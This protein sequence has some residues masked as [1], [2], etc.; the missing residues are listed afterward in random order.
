[1]L[2][3]LP[4]N[5]AGLRVGSGEQ[6]EGCASPRHGGTSTVGE[7]IQPKTLPRCAAS[8]VLMIPTATERRCQNDSR[9]RP[10][11]P[12]AAIPRL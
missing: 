5:L 10:G 6:N 8:Y 7:Y 4:E 12:K 11:L 1:M 2:A 3:R 9:C